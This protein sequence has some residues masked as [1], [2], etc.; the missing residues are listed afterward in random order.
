MSRA[1]LLLPRFIFFHKQQPKGT[2]AAV[3]GD[4]GRDFLQVYPLEGT[5]LFY[6]RLDKSQFF[7]VHSGVGDKENTSVYISCADEHFSHIMPGDMRETAYRQTAHGHFTLVQTD[8][9]MQ[10][11]RVAE[12]LHPPGDFSCF[13]H[14]V[15]AVD[16]RGGGNISP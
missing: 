1:A 7:I 15:G 10:Q 11:Q 4:S 14:H 12:A 2:G 3:A 8:D 6:K 13:V 9:G 16:D 5:I